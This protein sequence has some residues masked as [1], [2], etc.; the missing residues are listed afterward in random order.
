MTTGKVLKERRSPRH[1][2]RMGSS[3]TS[4]GSRRLRLRPRRRRARLPSLRAPAPAPASP[5][6]PTPPSST[7]IRVPR[8]GGVLS[9][10][11]Q[12]PA[13]RGGGIGSGDAIGQ[14]ACSRG[15]VRCDWLKHTIDDDASD[16]AAERD[17]RDGSDP[18]TDW[19]RRSHRMERSLGGVVNQS[20]RDG[21]RDRL[22]LVPSQRPD[23]ANLELAELEPA[24]RD[25]T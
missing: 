9:L 2:G 25:A 12:P 17:G 13:T 8:G 19:R 4:A 16:R 15:V 22:Q 6:S 14:F 7:V 5:R 20:P 24:E 18:R 1:R 23:A 21:G 11:R 3:L 10:R